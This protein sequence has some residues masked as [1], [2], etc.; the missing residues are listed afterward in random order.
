MVWYDTFATTQVRFKNSTGGAH[1][2]LAFGISEKWHIIITL[3]IV[4]IMDPVARSIADVREIRAHV[5]N[6]FDR[7]AL[8]EY[9]CQLG[10]EM[11]FKP[12]K[13]YRQGPAHIDCAWKDGNRVF[14]AINIEYGNER[15]ILGALAQM[16]IVRPE[17]AALITA[18]NPLKPITKIFDAAKALVPGR[19]TVIIDV[20]TGNVLTKES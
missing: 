18:S 5:E 7:D 2:P 4:K 8:K 1:H 12:F 10:S 17:V 20:K 13:N 9:F 11:G 16:I 3:H 14:A 6:I 19:T 15:E